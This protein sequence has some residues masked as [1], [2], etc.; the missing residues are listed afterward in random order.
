MA[1]KT[2]DSQKIAMVMNQFGEHFE[3]LKT[4]TGILNSSV[5]MSSA[6]A[7]PQNEVDRY[8]GQVAAENQI[9]LGVQ[10]DSLSAAAP[11]TTTTSSEA[12][13]QQLSA[14]EEKE[15]EKR[16]ASLLPK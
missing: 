7:V 14:D 12:L 16:L 4:N 8:L 1:V 2:M 13:F 3:G 5:A 11:S 15:L 6:S 10:M 9:K